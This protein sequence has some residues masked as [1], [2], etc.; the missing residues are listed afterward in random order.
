MRDA[1][2]MMLRATHR[3]QNQHA[4]RLDQ[5]DTGFYRGCY[6]GAISEI[7]AD[8]AKRD[9]PI[10]QAARTLANRFETHETMILRFIHDL[11]VPF[12]N[13]RAERERDQTCQDPPTGPRRRLAHPDRPGQVRRHLLPS[14]HRRQTRHRPDQSPDHT[15]R[16]PPLAPAAARGHL[17]RACGPVG[18][19]AGGG[20]ALPLQPS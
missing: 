5:T 10:A 20:V 9:D 2:L 12:T 19:V 16:R 8:N 3:A 11:A 17:T 6:H 14:D 1:L 7:R 13:N 15:L 18:H 4:D